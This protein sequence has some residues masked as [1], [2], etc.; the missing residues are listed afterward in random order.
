MGGRRKMRKETLVVILSMIVVL[1]L[2]IVIGTFLKIMKLGV[3]YRELQEENER[4]NKTI[5]YQKSVIMD[6][7]EDLKRG[8]LEC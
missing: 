6:L 5:Q 4:M 7:E 3:E 2:I 8:N 1:Y